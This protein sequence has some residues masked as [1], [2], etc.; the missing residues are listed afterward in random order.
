MPRPGDT[1]DE[2]IEHAILSL[3]EAQKASKLQQKSYY[4]WQA[5]TTLA[6]ATLLIN[7]AKRNES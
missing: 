3:Q 7:E 5:E 1:F 2:A 4:V 6:D